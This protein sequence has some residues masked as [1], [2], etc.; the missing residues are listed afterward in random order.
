MKNG[1]NSNMGKIIKDISNAIK[2]CK[3]CFWVIVMMS[4]NRKIKLM[5]QRVIGPTSIY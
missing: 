1:M 4:N 5:I 2:L 3:N